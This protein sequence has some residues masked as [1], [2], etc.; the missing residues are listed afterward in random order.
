MIEEGCAHAIYALLYLHLIELYFYSNQKVFIFFDHL[1]SIS[2]KSW[3]K[4]YKYLFQI[5]IKDFI[6]PKIH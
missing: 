5:K 4:A 2:T 6:Y 1:S 3:R